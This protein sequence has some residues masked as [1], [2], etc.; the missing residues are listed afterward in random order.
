[1][2]NG[3]DQSMFEATVQEITPLRRRR[4]SALEIKVDTFGITTTLYV[5]TGTDSYYLRHEVKSGDQI[6]FYLQLSDSQQA[7]LS[8]GI[9]PLE[10][11]EEPRAIKVLK[12]D[13]IYE[14][15]QTHSII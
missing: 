10:Q 13:K 12:T 1:M 6:Q 4:F 11:R 7:Y 14:F 2:V 9:N 3:E 8:Q 15:D 5:P